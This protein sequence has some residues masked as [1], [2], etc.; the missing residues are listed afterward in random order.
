M[1]TELRGVTCRSGKVSMARFFGGKEDGK[2]IQITFRKPDEKKTTNYG[3]S[4]FRY[5]YM[6]LT[7]EQALEMAVA[8][9]QFANDTR[10]KIED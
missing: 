3:M 10:E 9:V 7:E 1:A 6:Q 5:W 4:D 2:C 8:L